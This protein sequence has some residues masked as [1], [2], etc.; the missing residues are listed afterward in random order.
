MVILTLEKEELTKTKFIDLDDL[1]KYAN[2]NHL[3]KWKIKRD[4][5]WFTEKAWKNLKQIREDSK[6]WK[7]I[8]KVYLNLWNLLSDLKNDA[9]NY[10]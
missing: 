3:I 5:A 2:K 6:N 8:S 9:I 1:F 4:N 7:N 10:N